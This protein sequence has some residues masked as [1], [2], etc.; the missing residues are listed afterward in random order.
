[1]THDSSIFRLRQ[2]GCI[3]G[4]GHRADLVYFYQDAVSHSIGDPAPQIFCVGNK[5]VSPGCC[6]QWHRLIFPSVP[7]F[8]R[9]SS[10]IKMIGYLLSQFVSIPPFRRA[11]DLAAALIKFIVVIKKHFTA[12][13]IELWQSRHPF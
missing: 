9:H 3:D 11:D 2:L 7:I 10:S 12:G 5:P 13:G 8:F 4:F 1:M 6:G